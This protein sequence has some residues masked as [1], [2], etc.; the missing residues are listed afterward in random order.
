MH[1]T[2]FTNGFKMY[3]I[4]LFDGTQE[5]LDL[6]IDVVLLNQVSNL[7]QCRRLVVIFTR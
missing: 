4:T 5:C 6:F 3:S 7:A 1:Y 2:P